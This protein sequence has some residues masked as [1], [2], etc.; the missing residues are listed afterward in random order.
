[1]VNNWN[2]LKAKAYAAIDNHKLD[3]I[4]ADKLEFEFNEIEKQGANDYWVKLLNSGKKFTT[5]KNGLVMPFL[6]DITNI[7]PVQ[8]K[9]E[10]NVKYHPD[11]PDIDT[12]FLPEARDLIKAYAAAR[13]GET[14]VCSVGAW[15]EFKPKSAIQDVLA[16]IENDTESSIKKRH[17]AIAL[18]TKLPKEFDEQ[19]LESSLKE[20][21]P[22]Y[23]VFREYYKNN[24]TGIDLAYRAVNMLRSQGRHAAG[25]IISDRPI[26][27]YIPMTYKNDLWISEWTEGKK[28]QL[29][30]FGFVKFD[31]LGLLTLQYINDCVKIIKKNLNIDI[32]WSTMDPT[33]NIAGT[34]RKDDKVIQIPLDDKKSLKM[35]NDV[36]VET[37]FQFDTHL[38]MDILRRGGVKSIQDLIVYT[39]LGRPGPLPLIQVY[40]DRRDQK[41]TWEDTEHPR[42]TEILKDTYGITVFQEQLVRLFVELCGMTNPEAAHALKAVAKKKAD[43]LESLKPKI[44]NGAALVV[45]Q[46]RAE[47]LYESLV[48]FGRYAFNKCLDGSTKIKTPEGSIE[49]RNIKIGDTVLS[50]HGKMIIHARVKDVIKKKDKLYC[51]TLANGKK[52]RCTMEHKFMCSDGKYHEMKDI[53]SNNLD[54][55]E[56]HIED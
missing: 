52:I 21:G 9:I 26:G 29:S 17:E 55:Y 4:Y 30:K 28:T 32:D 2:E 27:D 42:I 56:E 18:T 46:E 43:V 14:Q 22:E 54:I 41:E 49:I 53:I 37:I 44:I 36:Q 33:K 12:D 11:F 34:L 8:C 40:L 16:A 23:D 1:M 7:D 35:A 45:G 38:A 25:L 50:R 31:I 24:K 19:S 51:F 5:N 15:Q 48:T 20:E 13:Y 10:H 6:L 47:S 3:Q 39:S